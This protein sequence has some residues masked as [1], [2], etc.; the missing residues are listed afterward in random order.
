MEDKKLFKKM[1]ALMGF[2]QESLAEHLDCS[3]ETV[4]NWEQGRTRIPKVAVL[5]LEAEAVLQNA[6]HALN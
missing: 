1:R 3:V 4:R 6:R 5:W 2:T